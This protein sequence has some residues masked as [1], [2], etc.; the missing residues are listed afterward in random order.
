MRDKHRKAFNF[1]A[2]RAVEEFESIEKIILFGSVARNEHGVNSDVDILI[3]TAD[4]HEWKDIEEL[5]LDVASEVGVPITPILKSESED[6]SLMKTI[7]QE[8]EEYVR[9]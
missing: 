7:G 6:S 2:E 4:E 8:G 5:A 1:F 3:K 9:S